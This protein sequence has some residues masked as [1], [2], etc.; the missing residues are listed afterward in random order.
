ML[1]AGQDRLGAAHELQLHGAVCDS[2]F[3]FCVRVC[4]HGTGRLGKEKR[5]TTV[6]PRDGAEEWTY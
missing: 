1:D 5:H 2:E 3:I 6:S 4:C